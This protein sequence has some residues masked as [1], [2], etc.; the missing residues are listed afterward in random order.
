MK[1]IRIGKGG[2]GFRRAQRLAGNVLRFKFFQRSAA[3]PAVLI[4]SR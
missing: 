4:V 1:Q 2:G 3:L